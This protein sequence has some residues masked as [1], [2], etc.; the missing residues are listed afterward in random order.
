LWQLRCKLLKLADFGTL[1]GE[2]RKAVRTKT[3]VGQNLLVIRNDWLAFHLSGQSPLVVLGLTFCLPQ[4][5]ID[6]QMRR[7]LGH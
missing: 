6:W 3:T 1:E 7:V 5:R 2:H 4:R